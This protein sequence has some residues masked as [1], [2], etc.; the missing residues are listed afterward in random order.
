MK[1]YQL[2]FDRKYKELKITPSKNLMFD[3]N[4]AIDKVVQ[5]NDCY[6]VSSDRKLLREKA[7]EIKAYWIS[8]TEKELEE[9]KDIKIVNRYW[10]LKEIKYSK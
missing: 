6:F 2:Y 4:K 7:Y 3:Y 1:F 9:F 10:V 8:Q 5:F